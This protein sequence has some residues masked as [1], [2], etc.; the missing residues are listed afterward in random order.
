MSDIDDFRKKFLLEQYN[1]LWASINIRLNLI[2][3][4]IGTLIS[5][6]AI[7]ALT[8]KNVIS[9]DIAT[10]LI[11]I[12]SGWLL[13]HIIDMSFWYNR[14]LVMIRNIERQFLVIQDARELYTYFLSHKKKNT[15]VQYLLIQSWLGI[16]ICSLVIFIHFIRV[17][18]PVISGNT[19]FSGIEILIPYL[20]LII[21]VIL[22]LR[23]KTGRDKEYVTF[24][25][26][27]PGKDITTETK[28][29]E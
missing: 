27:S 2:W 20:T 17:I 16:G 9:L 3:A 10:A 24:V 29:I 11:V 4:S 6:F 12:I 21:I 15:M 8:E 28:N 19:A 5:S 23:F 18:F 13:A 25:N 26:D 22:L 14:N 7:F 1:Q